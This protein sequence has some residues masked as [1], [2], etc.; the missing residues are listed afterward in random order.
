MAFRIIRGGYE[1]GA[2]VE[3][4]SMMASLARDV[5][6]ILG[7][8]IHREIERREEIE[9]TDDPL[10]LLAAE[11]A[12]IAEAIEHPDDGP[13]VS[14]P[15]TPSFDPHMPLDDALEKLLPDMSED[16]HEAQHLRQLTEES[17]A[18]NKIDHLTT[19]YHGLTSIPDAVDTVIV[20]ND[21]AE[22]WL[23][24]LNHI[25]LV[26]SARLEITDD[27]DTT[28]V[29]ERAGLFTGSSERETSNLPVIE[30]PEDMMAVLFAMTS[31]W[32]ESLVSAVRIKT[33]RR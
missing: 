32:Q 12:G 33:S 4:R 7:S 6:Y 11:V 21:D 19:F 23:S 13:D 8:D 27:D 15:D 30:T 26:L 25:R 14:D 2:S 5:I 10:A 16:P 18:G 24:A 22:A 3:E 1:A 31:W 9:S 28:R 17:I 29:Y 20:T